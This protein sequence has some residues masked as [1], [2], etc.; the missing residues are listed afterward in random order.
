[1]AS[2]TLGSQIDIHSGGIDLAF[3]HHDNE[4]AQSEAYWLEEDHDHQHQHQWVNYFMHMGHL[5]IQGS[6]MSKSLKNFQTIR[7]A[8]AG[9]DWTPR[10]LRIVFLLGHWADPVEITPD[11]RK[12]A[13]AWEDKLNVSCFSHYMDRLFF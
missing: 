5:S 7:E 13:T 12:E 2:D 1:M 11:L 6:K 4:L 9:G 8:L 10:E 3:P